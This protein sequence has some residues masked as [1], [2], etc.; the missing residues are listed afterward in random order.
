MKFKC[1]E[2]ITGKV[3]HLKTPRGIAFQNPSVLVQY[4]FPPWF[5]GLLMQRFRVILNYCLKP[6]LTIF[7]INYLPWLWDRLTDKYMNPKCSNLSCV[8]R[9][10]DRHVISESVK[11]IFSFFLQIT[12]ELFLSELPIHAAVLSLLKDAVNQQLGPL[13]QSTRNIGMPL[14]EIYLFLFFY[15]LV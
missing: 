9:I 15:M 8:L 13:Q 11:N 12:T 14:Q 2:L 3:L 10:T 5:T 6:C 4:A 1:T 7:F